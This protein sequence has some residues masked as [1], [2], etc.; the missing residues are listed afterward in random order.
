M[1]TFS[2]SGNEGEWKGQVKIVPFLH[3]AGFC[4]VRTNNAALPS[5]AD[6]F[7]GGFVFNIRTVASATN[8]T[9]FQ[10]QFQ[11]SAKIGPKQGGFQADFTLQ[12]SQDTQSVYVPFS[13]FVE[14][15]RGEKVGGAPNKEQLAKVIQVQIY[16]TTP[17]AA[18]VF[19]LVCMPCPTFVTE[20]A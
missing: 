13:S 20:I 7:S 8:L 16:V 5:V 6:Y 2:K 10:A 11:S 3:A 15:W 19:F 12:P 4:T 9:K 17:P 14:R 1:S 18:L